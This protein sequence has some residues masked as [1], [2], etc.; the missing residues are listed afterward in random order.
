[1]AFATTNGK[2][3][4][5]FTFIELMIV[6]VIVA[7]LISI[8][9]PSYFEGLTRSKE[10]VLKEDLKVIR[11]AIDHF[12]ADK[13]SYPKDLN[14]LVKQRYIS[15]IPEDPITERNDTWLVV[16]PPKE[17]NK[18]YDIHSGAQGMA[19]DGTYYQQW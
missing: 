14:E 18:L 7:L 5:G 12:H 17:S 13:S 16:S 9:L 19:S 15:A 11:N 2:A 4:K 8:A 3:I 10:T 1:M 6:L